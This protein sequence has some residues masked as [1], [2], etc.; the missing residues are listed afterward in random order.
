VR[1][2]RQ[3]I[4]VGDTCGPADRAKAGV[5]EG[6]DGW[7]APQATGRVSLGWHPAGRMGGGERGRARRQTGGYAVWG[8]RETITQVTEQGT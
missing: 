6:G 4:G 3:A 2:G 1:D 8:K 5:H 7:F